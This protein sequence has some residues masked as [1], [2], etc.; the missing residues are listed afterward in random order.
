MLIDPCNGIHM[1]GM[2]FAIDAL[3]LDRHNRV[4]KVFIDVRPWIGVVWIVL[5]A[6]KVLELPGGTLAS[7]GLQPGDQ[8]DL[9]LD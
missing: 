4:K 2:R 5:G 6:R 8:V 3:F 1:L 9:Q 7:I